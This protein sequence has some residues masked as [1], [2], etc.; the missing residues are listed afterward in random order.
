MLLPVYD[1]NPLR[2]IPFQFMTMSL[3]AVSTLILMWEVNL[4]Q[5][6]LERSMLVYGMIPSVLFGVDRLPVRRVY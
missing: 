2:I 1:R 6:M 3:I 4:P 5:R